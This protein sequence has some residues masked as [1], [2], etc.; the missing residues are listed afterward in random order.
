M[1][2][3]AHSKRT[4]RVR[5]LQVNI[6]YTKREGCVG[7]TSTHTNQLVT[8]VGWKRLQRT[9]SS[10]ALAEG[11]FCACENNWTPA[12]AEGDYRANETNSSR[13][14]VV[15]Q[16]LNKQKQL[17]GRNQLHACVGLNTAQQNQLGACVGYKRLLHIQNNLI[18]RWPLVITV[19]RFHTGF[20]NLF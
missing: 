1:R 11:D 7:L 15:G 16:L 3:L 10:P 6:A 13:A 14:F 2:L 8:C 17:D 12:L 19:Y 18:L 20:E 5:L 4:K 9:N